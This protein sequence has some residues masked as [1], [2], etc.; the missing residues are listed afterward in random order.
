V[1]AGLPVELMQGDLAGPS[2]IDRA[3][4]NIEVV[5]DL[6]KAVG[7]KW[8]DY[9]KHDVLVTQN[10]AQRALAKG[11]KRFIYT[12][13]IDSYYSARAG[14]VITSDTPLDPNIDGRNHYARSKAACEALL[15]EL[16]RKHDFPVVICRPGIVIGKG[17]PPA[18]WGVGTFLSDTRMQFWGNGQNKLPLV[19]VEDVANALVL[20]LDKPGI[21]GQA[22]LLTDE[23]LLNGR[24][25]VDA[26]SAACG[27]RIRAEPAPAWKYY[28]VDMLKE[29]AK[30]L[31]GHPNR[32]IP[33][34]RDWDS[35]ATA[36]RYDNAR[37]QKF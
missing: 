2:F 27:T 11:V 19:L 32:R 35:K 24:D 23:P 33:S 30:H 29:A 17:C 9:Y 34:Y 4:E 18:H 8:E 20:A 25:Y 16:H 13:T 37:P 31:I 6:A 14:D 15:M 22:L 28:A 7:S 5:Y 26:V 36:A 3:L 10:I 12:G 21:E 1:F